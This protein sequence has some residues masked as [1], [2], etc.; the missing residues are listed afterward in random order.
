[1]R[2]DE[3]NIDDAVLVVDSHDQPI[4]VP[5]NVEDDP[6]AGNKT[7]VG[8]VI[9]DILGCLPVGLERLVV[10]GFQRLTGVGVVWVAERL[11]AWRP[12]LR[13]GAV[14]WALVGA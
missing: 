12:R 1:V 8:I 9:L 7:R 5:A 4:L 11:A 10:P 6:V 13:A 14:T 2:T 3:S